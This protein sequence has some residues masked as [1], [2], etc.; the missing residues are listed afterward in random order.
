MLHNWTHKL[1]P[2]K[3]SVQ[4]ILWGLED[5]EKTSICLLCF[6]VQ[7]SDSTDAKESNTNPFM[8]SKNSFNTYY[9]LEGYMRVL[10]LRKL[11]CVKCYER[12]HNGSIGAYSGEEKTGI[13]QAKR[14]RKRSSDLVLCSIYCSIRV[15]VVFWCPFFSAIYHSPSWIS[16]ENLNGDSSP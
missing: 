8:Y 10:T 2:L 7:K 9:I 16:M 1:I 12:Q 3:Y 13:V 15:S 14:E 6:R 5:E 11:Q 4:R